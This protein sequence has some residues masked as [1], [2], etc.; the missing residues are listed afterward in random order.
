MG[1]QIISSYR[2]GL[3]PL[4]TRNEIEMLA[5]QSI[6]RMNTRKDFESKLDKKEQVFEYRRSLKPSSYKYDILSIYR[7]RD[8]RDRSEETNANV[9]L[10][11]V[12]RVP[13]LQYFS[14]LL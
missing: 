4:L 12:L 11:W 7:V 2:S 3:T 9:S 5:I 10:S 6:L 8:T 13:H 14:F 1:R